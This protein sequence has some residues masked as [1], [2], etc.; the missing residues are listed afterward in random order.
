MPNRDSKMWAEAYAGYK[1][2]YQHNALSREN[3]ERKVR[4]KTKK[5]NF[6]PLPSKLTV[7][8]VSMEFYRWKKTP[9][10]SKWRRRQFLK[11]GGTCFYC[12]IPLKGIRINVEHIIPRSKGGTNRRE[13][14]VLACWECNNKK[15]SE[16]VPTAT[17]EEHRKRNKTKKGT[18]HLMQD[19]EDYMS[20]VEFALVLKERFRED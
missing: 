17:L 5:F 8:Q 18:Y 10:F 6:K 16:L 2:K 20:D 9:E 11:Q 3:W 13:N 12:D 4:G 15:R 19:N 7:K 14:L 1:K